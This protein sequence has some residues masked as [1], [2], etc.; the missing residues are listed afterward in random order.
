MTTTFDS[1]P[2]YPKNERAAVEAAARHPDPFIDHMQRGA[3]FH[4]DRL[5]ELAL[6]EFEA[7]A[8]L[9]P[10]EPNPASACASVLLELR[11]PQAAW[12]AL[13]PHRRALMKTADGC[14]NLALVAHG[15]GKLDDARELLEHALRLDPD[16]VPTLSRLATLDMASGHTDSALQRAVHQANVAPRAPEPRLQLIDSLLLTRRPSDALRATDTAIQE[17]AGAA[18]AG[19][20]AGA[21]LR[22]R[23]GIAHTVLGSWDDALRSF[24]Q[25]TPAAAQE[26]LHRIGLTAWNPIGNAVD[27]SGAYVQYAAQACVESEWIYVRALAQMLA[28]LLARPES[29]SPLAW[30]AARTVAPL[31]QLDEGQLGAIQS[32]VDLAIRHTA[33]V[34]LHAQDNRRVGDSRM[35]IG[36]LAPRLANTADTQS[37]CARL[38][39]HDR[40]RFALHVYTQTPVPR[41][42]WTQP[43]EALADSVVHLSH[44][45]D[46]EL[47]TRMR[48]D[49]LD[50][51]VDVA[52]GTPDARP[53]VAASR[54]APVQVRE[55]RGY[56]SAIASGLYDYELTD[57][58]TH[59]ISSGSG[60]MPM[61][62][63]PFAGP[64]APAESPR[65]INQETASGSDILIAVAAPAAHID[66]DSL[67]SWS[68]ILNAVPGAR[69]G[70][71]APGAVVLARL[72]RH[73]AAQGITQDRLQSIPVEEVSRAALVLDTLRHSAPQS[74]AAG[75]ARGVPTLACA[76]HT[77]LSQGGAALLKAA[78]LRSWV[79]A[80]PDEYERRAI[81][82]LSSP[83]AALDMRTQWQATKGTT[84]WWQPQARARQTE[85]AW[86]A[87][88]TR[89]RSGQPP[90]PFDVPSDASLPAAP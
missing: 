37:L 66:A 60:A 26:A 24:S 1:V 45:T 43:V 11:R 17:L 84:A 55:M 32:H 6:V 19:A 25:T 70:I 36:I 3:T 5:A 82:I 29:A 72:R 41:L 48:L 18:A 52:A 86:H 42:E 46:A 35:R 47:I 49:L 56:P 76:T 81:E 23:Q 77:S 61:V 64:H 63:L 33:V 58:L 28:T 75:L 73:A 71:V 69:L 34:K 31:L 12:R 54:V 22:A 62:R 21:A 74:L 9:K 88:I 16:H 7:A 38:N 8:R 27:V 10:N 57:V 40:S 4:R 13:E 79:A 67:A 85:V 51:L 15:V 87:L 30:Q 2:R 89:A 78:G 90:A 65:E 14:N 53:C 59:A 68:R 50:L 20:P 80:S 83:Q 39:G 44:L